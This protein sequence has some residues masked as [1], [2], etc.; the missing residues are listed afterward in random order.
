MSSLQPIKKIESRDALL[1]MGLEIW[2]ADPE[3]EWIDEVGKHQFLGESLCAS[4]KK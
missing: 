3:E 2:P 4:E 1:S